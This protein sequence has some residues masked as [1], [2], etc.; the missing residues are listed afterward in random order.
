[1]NRRRFL[2]ATLAALP[3]LERAF[4]LVAPAEPVDLLALHAQF[5]HAYQADIFA[6]MVAQGSPIRRFV[7]ER[8]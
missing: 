1:M 8:R 5:R 6:A 2:F 4:A 3:L 7:V